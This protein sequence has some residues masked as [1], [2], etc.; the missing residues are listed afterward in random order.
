MSATTVS[1]SSA[2]GATEAMTW[3]AHDRLL[4][5][6]VA[7]DA[8]GPG[9]GAVVHRPDEARSWADHVIASVAPGALDG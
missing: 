1:P 5:G 3:S 2:P 6:T 9:V 4:D 8:I 7:P